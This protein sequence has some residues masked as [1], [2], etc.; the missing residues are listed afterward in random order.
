MSSYMSKQPKVSSSETSETIQNLEDRGDS[1]QSGTMS[2]EELQKIALAC[3][4]VSKYTLKIS[5]MVYYH[6]AQYDSSIEKVQ[7]I[8]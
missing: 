2:V 8:A 4:K 6:Y 1:I 3:E 5:L 7:K